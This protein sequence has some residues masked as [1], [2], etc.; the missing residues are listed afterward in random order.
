MVQVCDSGQGP[1]SSASLSAVLTAPWTSPSP[2]KSSSTSSLSNTHPKLEMRAGSSPA[3][4]T[5]LVGMAAFA[6]QPARTFVSPHATT[7]SSHAR[8]SSVTL[9]ANPCVVKRCLPML[10]TFVRGSRTT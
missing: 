8:G 9:T 3:T 10:A 4:V 1:A 5:G 7:L 6:M 2:S